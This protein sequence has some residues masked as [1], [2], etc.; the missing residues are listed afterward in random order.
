[1][2]TALLLPPYGSGTTGGRG[3]E[4]PP[5]LAYETV[6]FGVVSTIV[7]VSVTILSVVLP[8]VIPDQLSTLPIV[9][10]VLLVIAAVLFF[11]VVPRAARSD[12]PA[13]AGL[14]CAVAGLVLL[15]AFWSGLSIVLG[16]AGVML[17]RMGQT[18][19]RGLALA[20]SSPVRSQWSCPFSASSWTDC[21]PKVTNGHVATHRSGVCY[22]DFCSLDCRKKLYGN[23]G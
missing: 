9:T 7:A 18:T 16:A 8:P 1:M 4:S 14:V 12:R 3:V 13:V 15:P 10:V 22:S 6:I 17:G 11:F 21:S 19:G 20:A 5:L 23:S 2:G